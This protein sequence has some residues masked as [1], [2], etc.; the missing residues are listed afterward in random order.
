[1]GWWE[2]QRSKNSIKA[3]FCGGSSVCF[4]ASVFLYS[5]LLYFGWRYMAFASSYMSSTYISLCIKLKTGNRE[6]VIQAK[7][8]SLSGATQTSILHLRKLQI[9]SVD[10]LFSDDTVKA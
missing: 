8:C 6:S 4:R 5:E 1:M 10:P 3:D 2:M 7:M 9:K